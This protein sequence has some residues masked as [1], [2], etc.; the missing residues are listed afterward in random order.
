MAARSPIPRRSGPGRPEVHLANYAEVYRFFGRGRRRHRFTHA[1]LRLAT[2]LWAPRVVVTPEVAAEVRRLSESGTGIVVASNHPS[3]HDAMVIAAVLWHR[4]L[5]ILSSG[6]AL[7][8]DSL[9]SGP[10]R[11]VFEYTGTIPVFRA[12]NYPDVPPEIHIAAAHRMIEV[13]VEMLREGNA[14]LYFVEGTNSATEDLRAL[15]RES[16]K[17]GI[18]QIVHDVHAAGR[19][20][21]LLP[22][23]LNYRG[24]E[25]SSQPPRGT[26]ATT[27]MPVLW[28]AS[29]PTPTIDEV[30]EVARDAINTGLAESRR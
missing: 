25:K 19:P 9:F 8:K 11:P 23:A 6:S 17:Q 16:V 20:V 7:A 13:C 24:Q 21:A 10:M 29:A 4:P 30:R 14:V 18:G 3:K 27:G 15:R 2:L 28:D 26:V 5:R 1:V 22:V 12:K